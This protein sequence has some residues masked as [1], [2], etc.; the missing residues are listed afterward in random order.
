MKLGKTT[1]LVILIGVFVVIGISLGMVHSKQVNEQDQLKEKLVQVQSRSAVMQP[2]Q[3]SSRKA[4]L[5]TQ[6]SQT[7]SQFEE[8]EAVLSQPL[9]SV[10][11]TSTLFDIAED[12]GV[13]VTEMTSPGLATENLEGLDCLVI[14]LTAKVEGD[15]SNLVSFITE[16]NSVFTTGVVKSITITVTG[17]ASEE[18]ALADLNLV[19]Y[20]YQGD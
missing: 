13:E 10:N 17:N 12:N 9:V 11:V 16:L 15:V 14:P 18:R 1:R 20:S 8:V 2:G 7:T 19:V 4:E 3:L 5:E 6:L